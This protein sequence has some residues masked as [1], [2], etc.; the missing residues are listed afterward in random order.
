MVIR[1]YNCPKCGSFE[2]QTSIKEDVLKNCPDCG[3]EL[4]RKFYNPDILWCEVNRN[5][6]NGI[7]PQKNEPMLVR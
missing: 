4:K 5:R 6:F 2:T 1:E 3:Q 7:N